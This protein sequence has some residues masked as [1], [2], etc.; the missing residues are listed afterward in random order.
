MSLKPLISNPT[1]KNGTVFSADAFLFV[2]ILKQNGTTTKGGDLEDP[3]AMNWEEKYL[4]TFIDYD[5]L[6]RNGAN[7]EGKPVGA[8]IDFLADSRLA[9]SAFFS[10]SNIE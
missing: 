5:D 7:V 3:I 10:A 9:C 2:W 4:D 1:W 6:T 8:E